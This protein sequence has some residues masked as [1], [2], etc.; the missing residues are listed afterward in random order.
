VPWTLINRPFRA[1]VP[2]VPRRTVGPL[3]FGR[4]SGRSP[5]RVPERES[6]RGALPFGVPGAFTD[7]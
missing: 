7:A 6:G 5:G 3:C 2:V 4:M 1:L